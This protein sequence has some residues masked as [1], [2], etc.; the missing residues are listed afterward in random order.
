MP[1]TE[2]RVRRAWRARKGT[3]ARPVSRELS[4]RPDRTG[5]DPTGV[6]GTTGGS[7]P[8]GSGGS[9][10][11][12][13]GPGGAGAAGSGGSG[14]GMAGRGGAAGGMAGRGGGSGGSTGGSGPAG[15][16]GGSAPGGTGGG[17]LPTIPELFPV[18]ST[19][20][21]SFDG[22]LGHHAVRRQQR[23][24]HRLRRRRRVLHDRRRRNHRHAHQLLGQRAQRQPGVQRRRRDGQD[25]QRHRPLL[26]NRGAQ[27]L[28]H[29]IT[30]RGGDRAPGQHA[31]TDRRR[32]RRRRRGRRLPAA[33]RTRPRTTTPTRSAS[34]GP[35]PARPPTRSRS[36]TSTPTPARATGRT[37]S[38]TR[39]RSP[40]SAAA[41]FACATTT[42]TAARS[43]TA[44]RPT[45]RPTSAPPTANARIIT[46]P[47]ATPMPATGAGRDAAGSRSRISIPAR[48]RRLC[49]T[50]AA[51]RRRQ[52][53]LSAV[54]AVS[55]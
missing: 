38:T 33:T 44:V 18:T 47:S 42:G 11:A 2:R 27:G 24:R 12:G 48:S 1:A 51:H 55:D 3:P 29:R 7:G 28:R 5:G 20:V 43:R 31:Q 22:R 14:G 45:W 4:G 52:H 23:L 13:S 34:A 19:T 30:P 50:V 6:A 25:V 41:P 46:T 16:S 15:S 39:S 36:T 8:A 32:R 17:G 9:G 54:A 26:R 49:G 37:S 10:P 35:A 21:G 40:S 53:Q